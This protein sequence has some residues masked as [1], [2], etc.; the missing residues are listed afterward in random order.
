M[1]KRSSASAA[2]A[3]AD[4]YWSKL[5]PTAARIHTPEKYVNDAI[6]RNVQLAQDR[7]QEHNPDTGEYSFLSGSYG[8]DGLWAT[9]TSMVSHM[10]LDLLGYHDVVE[11]H[12]RL[13]LKNQG[14]SPP[15]GPAFLRH[16]GYFSTPKSLTTIDW[17]TDHGAVLEQLSRHALLTGDAEFTNRYLDAIVKGCDFIK[18]AVALRGHGGVEGVM[19]PA[20]AT[21]TAFPSKRSGTRPGTTRASRPPSSCSNT[22]TTPS[23]RSSKRSQELSRI[24]SNARS[25]PPPPA[26]RSGQPEGHGITSSPPI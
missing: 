8:Y 12:A 3:K 9:P 23:P 20:V 7:R 21:D 10:F 5:P 6:A 1:P 16:P 14:T 13:F 24:R 17:L 22:S 18:Y 11:K 25:P 4:S 26:N 15:A 19:P 2:L